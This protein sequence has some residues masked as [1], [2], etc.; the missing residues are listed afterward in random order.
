MMTEIAV[1]ASATLNSVLFF[2]FS[3]GKNLVNVLAS[4]FL[5][6]FPSR[7]NSLFYLFFSFGA[8]G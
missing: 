5:I 7:M 6:F 2:F 4:Y 3:T 8:G 1:G